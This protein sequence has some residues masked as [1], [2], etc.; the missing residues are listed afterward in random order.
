VVRL[1]WLLMKA[2]A[3]PLVVL[4]VAAIGCERRA[5]TLGFWFEDVTF[6]SPVLGG[7]LNADDL[8]VI[9]RVAREELAIA[10]RG[11][12]VT[13]SDRKDARYRVRVT[14]TIRE[15]RMRREAVVAGESRGV[16][17]LGGMG[18]VNFT[19]YA[20]GAIVFAPEAATRAEIVAAI[21]RGLGRGAVHEF[22]HQLV[23]GA[24]LHDGRD[25][26]SY[27]Y[28]AASREEQYYGP[29]HW[30]IA[31]PLLQK[32]YGAPGSTASR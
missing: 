2:R 31:G 21:G 29:M 19:Y 4:V 28:Y 25:R 27:E 17:W 32:Q 18:A 24:E 30:D 3:W 11:L 13:L 5:A 9:E 1:A 12:D 16:P 6:G 8:R 14:Q 7:A 22:A 23:R 20:S 15:N 26:G 10:F